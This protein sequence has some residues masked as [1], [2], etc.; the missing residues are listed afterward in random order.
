MMESLRRR[1]LEVLFNG[2]EAEEDLA[3]VSENYTAAQA[4][5]PELLV[6][7]AAK[8][9]VARLAARSTVPSYGELVGHRRASS[10][11]DLVE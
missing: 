5:F 4:K 2:P 10:T 3:K 9:A 11:F 6:V 8:E 1:F 7:P